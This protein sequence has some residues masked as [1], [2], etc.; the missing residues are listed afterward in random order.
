[1]G[2]C[3]KA[4]LNQLLLLQKRCLRTICNSEYLAPT[5]NLFL[6]QNILTIDRLY[7][8]NC[9]MYVYRNYRDYQVNSSGYSTRNSMLICTDFAR[10]KTSDNSIFQNAPK[11]FNELPLEL[12][13]CKSHQMFKRKLKNYLLRA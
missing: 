13:N 1:M 7:K 5:E 9:C 11:F 6:A 8:F 12:K 2:G 4:H 3:A 10:L